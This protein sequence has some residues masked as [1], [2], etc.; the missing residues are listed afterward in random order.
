[1][2][3]D[4]ESLLPAIEAVMSGQRVFGDEIVDK[5]PTFFNSNHQSTQQLVTPLTTK[6]SEIVYWLAEGVNNKEIAEQMHFSEGTIRTTY[7]KY[8]I[9]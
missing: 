4:Y 6:E 2:K 5:I 1:M 7:Q 9:N 3:T 8:W